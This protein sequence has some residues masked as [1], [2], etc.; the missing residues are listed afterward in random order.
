VIRNSTGWPLT[1]AVYPGA[2]LGSPVAVPSGRN[3]S[4]APCPVNRTSPTPGTSSTSSCVVSFQVPTT[5]GSTAADGAAD[6]VAATAPSRSGVELAIRSSAAVSM[7][8]TSMP[9]PS[10]TNGVA[11][12]CGRYSL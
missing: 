9:T 11:T 1:V 4:T 3:R 8:M 6:G 12:L 5:H 10:T 2:P 7:R